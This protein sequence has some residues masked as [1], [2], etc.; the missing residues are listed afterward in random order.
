MATDATSFELTQGTLS[1]RMIPVGPLQ[2]NCYLVSDADGTALLVDPGGDGEMLLELVR[3]RDLRLA[4]LLL[5]HGHFDHTGAVRMLKD[6][7]KAPVVASLRE[8]PLLDGSANLPVWLRAPGPPIEID[9]PA[10]EGMPLSF[11]GIEVKVIETP[12]HTPGSVSYLIGRWLFSG[13]TLFAGSVGRTDL[14][15]SLE[16]LMPSLEKLTTL[17]PETI[18]LPGHLGATTLEHEIQYNPYFRK[19]GGLR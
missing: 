10:R 11:G 1:V 14:G 8:K 13:D 17:P 4:A 15:G 9:I 12:G 3:A 18:V 7:T 19:Q 2:T 6:A 16:D 5:T